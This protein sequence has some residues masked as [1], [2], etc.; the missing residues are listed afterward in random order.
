MINVCGAFVE[1][2]WQGETEV[3]EE[4]PVPS[5]T[6]SKA[7]PTRTGL[8]FNPVLRSER[9]CISSNLSSS[10]QWKQSFP[11]VRMIETNIHNPSALSVLTVYVRIT[12]NN[13]RYN[14]RISKLQYII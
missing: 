14:G 11:W 1:W 9:R 6:L 10:K 5:A 2:R 13:V 3:L 7:N 4:N 12:H 8:E